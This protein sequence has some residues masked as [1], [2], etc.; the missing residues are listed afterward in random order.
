MYVQHSC[1]KWTKYRSRGVYKSLLSHY[2]PMQLSCDKW[3]KDPN[4]S[5]GESNSWTNYPN[6]T[7][8]IIVAH[9]KL[10]F[11][12]C[13]SNHD[14]VRSCFLVNQLDVIIHGP[15][16]V[17][18]R[19]T[20]RTRTLQSAQKCSWSFSFIKDASVGSLTSENAYDIPAVPASCKWPFLTRTQ[21]RF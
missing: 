15:R 11:T 4:Q 3:T 14:C 21:V 1:D 13:L 16:T 19:R 20:R 7:N 18:I 2:Y 17:P 8:T 12:G 5:K 9:A 10:T 6:T